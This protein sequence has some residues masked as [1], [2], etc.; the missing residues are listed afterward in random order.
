MRFFTQDNP[1]MHFMND[2]VYRRLWTGL[3]A[4]V[5]LASCQKES[6]EAAPAPTPEPTQPSAADLIKD[7]TLEISRELYLW[8]KQIPT[9]FKPR[10]YDGPVEIMEAIRQYST[11]PGFDKPVDKWSFA[12]KQQEWDKVSSGVGGDFGLNVFFLEEGD[13]RV[14]MVE[15]SSPAGKA[16]VRRGWRIT[17]LNGSTNI[18][19]ANADAIVKAVYQSTATKFVFEKPDGTTSEISLNAGAYQEQPVALDT[20]YNTGGKS[21]GYLVF[22]SFLGDTAQIYSRFQ[23]SF[24]RFAA[25]NVGDVIVDLR[26]NGGGYVTV[27]EKLAGYLA[28]LAAN[29]DVLMNQEYN[30]KYSQYNSTARVSKQGSLN[31]P[32]VFFIVSSGTASASELIINNLKPYM[33]VKLVGPSNTYGKP[34]GYFN[35]P[36]GDWY[37]FPVSFRSTNKLSQGNYFDGFQ[38][39]KKVADGI[40]KEMGDLDESCLASVVKYITTGTYGPSI[41]PKSKATDIVDDPLLLETNE[42]LVGR[43]FKGMIQPGKFR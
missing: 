2:T 19:Y 40:D 25:A 7:S 13:L 5:L 22:N 9:T 4:L 42:K 23:Q 26:Y 18:T 36:V 6:D 20:V 10:S 17:A 30:D 28:P 1:S 38:V 39:D 41:R 24:S 15:P 37:V 16:G 12:V 27:Q 21:I 32:R 8:Y 43:H 33:D 14:R 3:V 31:M 11:E 29:G 35:I 34:V